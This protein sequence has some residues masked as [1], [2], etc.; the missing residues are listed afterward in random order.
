MNKNNVTIKKE[1]I[2]E[3]KNPTKKDKFANLD[4]KMKMRLAI[5]TGAKV[6][7]LNEE[8]TQYH[9]FLLE[10]KKKYEEKFSFDALKR[11][12]ISYYIS[13]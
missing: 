11:E 9:N 12:Y 1:T 8:Q 3:V 13:L 10:K 7:C 2:E 5:I 4:W 6:K